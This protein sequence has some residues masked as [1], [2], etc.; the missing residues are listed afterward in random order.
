MRRRGFT[1][2]EILLATLIAV[3]VL[4]VGWA[5]WWGSYRGFA[6]GVA[7]AQSLQAANEALDWLSRDLACA[8]LARTDDIRLADGAWSFPIV[9]RKGKARVNARVEWRLAPRKNGPAFGLV[10]DGQPV[11]RAASIL[12]LTLR[13]M[14]AAGP[15]AIEIIATDASGRGRAKLVRM[16]DVPRLRQRA[17]WATTW[18]Q[19]AE[20]PS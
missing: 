4:G 11:L 20:N 10:R 13:P 5:V 14:S 7:T 9:A 6:G 16:V 1:L 2:I 15:I 8:P 19:T 17:R 3:I 18:E 12:S